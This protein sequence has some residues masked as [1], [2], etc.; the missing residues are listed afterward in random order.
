MELIARLNIGGPAVLVL[1]L[2]AGLPEQGIGVSVAAGKVGPGEASMDFW[3]DARKISWIDVRG[4]TPT[5]GQGNSRAFQEIR[6]LLRENRP[7]ILHTHT[8]KAGTL[9]RAAAVCPGGP[10][11]PGLVH[12]FHGHVFKGYFPPWKTRLFLMV[13]RMLARFTDR[14]VVLSEEQARDISAVYRICPR[15]KVRII[16]VGLDLE[17][18]LRATG[19]NLRDELGISPETYVIGTIGR[20][21]AIKD[22]ATLLRGLARAA[23]GATRSLALVVVGQGELEEETRREAASLGIQAHFIGWRPGTA[24]L[25][26][27]LD[28]VALTSLNEGLPLVLLEALAASRPV[29]ATPVGGVPSLLGLVQEPPRGGFVAAER[30]L[31]FPVGDADGLAQAIKWAI[32]HSDKTAEAA[33]RGREHVLARHSQEGFLEAHA[34]LYEEVYKERHGG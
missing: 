30:G 26:P 23:R 3:A 2:A 6:S 4:L 34:R 13:E 10:R 28:L 33:S 5:L 19:Q 17:P 25:L 32:A 12:T 8:A 24:D 11:R 31:L 21:T 20:L 1:D 18:F 9:G 16:P 29:L 27:S 7:D 15:E 14:I 22:H